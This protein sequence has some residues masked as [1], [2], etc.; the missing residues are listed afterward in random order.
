MILGGILGYFLAK[1]RLIKFHISESQFDNTFILLIP[2]AI[3]GAR[4]YHVFSSFSYYLKNPIEIFSFRQGGLGIY[5]AVMADV[6]LLYFLS[7]KGKLDLLNFLDLVSPSIFLMQTIGRIGNFF[8]QEVFGPPT[9]LPWRF[10]VSPNNRPF[11]WEHYS[12]FHP[13]FL[14]ESIFSFIF[15]VYLVYLERRI[16]PKTGFSFG[17]YLS[18]YGF[19]RFFLEFWRFDTWQI[20]GVKI[21]IFFSIA[22]V[23]VGLTLINRGIRNRKLIQ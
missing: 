7:K 18:S 21:G 5:G 3:I 16:R 14:Y 1:K 19:I 10:Y 2:T 13:I 6:L 8:N 23:V 20:N 12:Y 17:F 11:N 9:N 15:M 4:I 22:F